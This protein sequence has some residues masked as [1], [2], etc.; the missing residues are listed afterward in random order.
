MK[1]NSSLKSQVQKFALPLFGCLALLG[2][3]SCGT[4]HGV[5][6]DVEHAG[7]EIQGAAR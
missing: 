4:M 5:G 7:E 3:S 6:R 1:T 2:I